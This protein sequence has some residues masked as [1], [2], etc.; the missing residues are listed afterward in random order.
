MGEPEGVEVGEA[1]G[2]A[3]TRRLNPNPIRPD[4][5][6]SVVPT[7][8]PTDGGEVVL[9]PARLEGPAPGV[10]VSTTG[11]NRLFA[12]PPTT[13]TELAT[14]SRSRLPSVGFGGGGAGL[15]MPLVGGFGRRTAGEGLGTSSI[16]GGPDP[17]L[18]VGGG[19]A[20]MG[21]ELGT[22]AASEG[23]DVM[24]GSCCAAGTALSEPLTGSTFPSSAVPVLSVPTV[25][26]ML[27]AAAKHSL[28]ALSLQLR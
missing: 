15:R 10:S 22:T 11:S 25:F 26:V 19:L 18:E 16:P 4:M 20:G 3:A 24:S 12:P 13:L 21:A 1:L 9:G 2:D 28:Y 5:A 14:I 8:E 27:C 23:R 6:L 7:V 17:E